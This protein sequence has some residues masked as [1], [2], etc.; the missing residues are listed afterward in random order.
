MIIML[1][2]KCG[3]CCENVSIIKSEMDRILVLRPNLKERIKNILFNGATYV[4]KGTCPFLTKEKLCEINDIKPSICLTF[5][6]VFINIDMDITRNYGIS[7]L[8]PKYNT[9]TKT[10][11]EY[12]I[13]IHRKALLDLF[14][15]MESLKK[16]GK[17]NYLQ[18]I[19]E[20]LKSE[21]SI[22]NQ[23]PNNKIIILKDYIRQGS[24][25]LSNT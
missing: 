21:E 17:V 20:I 19:S 2:D 1:C 13:K 18:K 25:S 15:T 5:P 4:I 11:I 14:R 9:L 16:D 7:T 24:H 23:D 6:L 22:L 8:C 10:D 3:K 12:G